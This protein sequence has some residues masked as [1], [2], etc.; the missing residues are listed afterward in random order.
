MIS[1]LA[2]SYFWYYYILSSPGLPEWASRIHRHDQQTSFYK[3]FEEEDRRTMVNL[4]CGEKSLKIVSWSERMRKRYTKFALKVPWKEQQR[5][6][7]RTPQPVISNNLP[8][9]TLWTGR[10]PT[11]GCFLKYFL[12]LNLFFKALVKSLTSSV[13][14]VYKKENI[15]KKMFRRSKLQ[16]SH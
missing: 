14:V 6:V 8:S 15:F 1:E 13:E 9:K 4:R 5:Q 16:P 7:E 2:L 10:Y 12:L 11:L 3:E